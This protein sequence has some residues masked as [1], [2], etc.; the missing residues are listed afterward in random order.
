MLKKNVKK[1]LVD[2]K[3]YHRRKFI[4]KLIEEYLYV[5][6]FICEISTWIWRMVNSKLKFYQCSKK[7]NE[8][9]LSLTLMSWPTFLNVRYLE[10]AGRRRKMSLNVYI[11]HRMDNGMN[12]AVLN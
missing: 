9:G 2:E 3:H 8:F 7:E 4:G 10:K 1:S 12:G 6:K 11:K 5:N